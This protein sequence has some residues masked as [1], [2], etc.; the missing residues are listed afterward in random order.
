MA[1]RP[2]TTAGL[3]D[4]PPSVIARLEAAVGIPQPLPLPNIPT[5]VIPTVPTA[6]LWSQ[7]KVLS[8]LYRMRVERTGGTNGSEA[9]PNTDF[10]GSRACI[11]LIS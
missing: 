10:A 5:A 8:V 1:M 4:R 9:N 7:G 2:S 11:A 6:R 3:G